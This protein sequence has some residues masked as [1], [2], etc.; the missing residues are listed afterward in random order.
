MK[1]ALLLPAAAVLLLPV[2][3]ALAQDNAPA[4]LEPLTVTANKRVQSLDEVDGAVTVRTAEDLEQAG[5]TR[6]DDLERVFPGLMIRD[7]GN[8]AYSNITVRGVTSPDFYNPAVQVYVDGVPQDQ[9]Y[10][11][12]QLLNVDRIELLRGPQGTLYGRNAYGGVINIVTRKP[13]DK[14]EGLVGGEISSGERRTDLLGMAP[15]VPGKLFGEVGLRWSQ[16]LGRIDNLT[17]GESDFDDA[18]SRQ[19]RLRLRYAPTGGPLDISVSAQRETLRGHDEVY[20]GDSNLGYQF[21]NGS[22]GSQMT[23]E[24][25][26]NSYSLS[27]DYDFGSAKLSSITALQDRS[28]PRIMITPPSLVSGSSLAPQYHYHEE[29]DSLSQELRLSF[30]EGQRLSGVVGVYAQATDFRRMQPAIVPYGL[31]AS[32]ND[33]NTKSYAGFGEATYKLTEKL[34]LTAGLRYALEQ[35]EVDYAGSFRFQADDSFEDISP[36][37]ALGYQLAPKSRVYA[38]VSRGFKPGGFNHAVSNQNDRIPYTSE[39][40]INYEIGWRAGLFGGLADLSTAAYYILA[41]EKQFYVGNPGSQVLRN[42]GDAE[43]RGVE[44]DVSVYPTKN[45]TVTGGLAVGESTFTDARDP[46]NGTVYDGKTVPYAPEQIYNLS[47]RYIIPQKALPGELSL[48]GAARYYSETFFNE[49]NSLS[50]GGYSLFDASVDLDLDNGLMLGLFADNIA[51]KLYR[52]SSYNFSGST[53]R[54]TLGEGRVIGLNG[55]L[56]F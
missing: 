37:I 25:N 14:V 6:V 35:A 10:F 15:L 27:V 48:R 29:Q 55:R 53:R 8:R 46:I 38:S 40:S 50:Q 52:T 20:V 18:I 36:K 32:R 33:V 26:V 13:S 9:T 30:G 4:V 44:L 12:Q 49:A 7:R 5:V 16:E 22:F 2:F 17:S 23:Y 1:N 31:S 56:R 24:R 19:G 39:T 51:D 3:T 43:S 42:I 21:A 47:A 28:M 41:Q 45:L 54:S 11:T 34:D